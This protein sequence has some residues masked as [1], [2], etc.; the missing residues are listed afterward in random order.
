MEIPKVKHKLIRMTT[1]PGSLGGLLK[2]QLK[3]M[4]EHFEVI[5]VSSSENGLL[6]K[7][8]SREKVPVVPIEMT[9]RITPFKDLV[10]VWKLYRLFKREKPLIVHTHTPKA[11]TLGML[12][13]YL[14][15]VPYRL[16][17]IAGL[18]LL[19]A[20]GGKRKLLD[21]VEKLTY[22][23]A[24]KIYPN[25]FGL[26]DIILENGYTNH[27]KLKVIGNGSS[28]GVDTR[29]FN[30]DNFNKTE[31][32]KLRERLK[33]NSNDFVFLFVGRIVGDKGIN[34]LIQAFCRLKKSRP[35]IK[36]ILLGS[37]ER[38][39][40]PIKSENEERIDTDP[41]ILALGTVTDVRPYFCIADCMAFPSYREG[42]PNV[43]MEAGAM[44]VPSI[45]TDINGCNEIIDH[46]INGVIVPTKDEE[47]L[48]KEMKVMI[49]DISQNKYDPNRIRQLVV[50]KY[51]R[52]TMWNLILEEYL[53][54][55]K[56]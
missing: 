14:A 8:G 31:L 16:H 37:Y 12:A 6:E 52:P 24:T 18:P 56:N 30:R 10:S 41:N 36:L 39:L 53:E 4:K 25:S 43:V 21:L 33:I 17:T 42:F 38:E 2:G 26:K 45:V 47:A 23:W 27:Q 54:L 7:V 35:N 40:D 32:L 48:Y 29:I 13:A 1:I 46:G 20:T 3:F 49:N 51:D 22:F 50:S 19:E 55:I 34:E 5:G 15:R 11:G 9:R 44:G 28:N